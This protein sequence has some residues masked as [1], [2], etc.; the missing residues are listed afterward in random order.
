LEDIGEYA[1]DG[2][3]SLQRITTLHTVK[4]I[5]KSAFCNCKQLTTVQL[6]DGLEEI[7]SHA[8]HSCTLLEHIETPP[9]VKVIKWGT[10]VMCT[11]MRTVELGEGMEVIAHLELFRCTSLEHITITPTVTAINELA[12]R[13]CSH[14]TTMQFRSEIEQ[15]VSGESMRGW[16]N[17]WVHKWSPSTYCFLVRCN[18]FTTSKDVADPCKGIFLKSLLRV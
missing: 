18:G 9:D 10:F 8:F 16:W 1:F 3:T 6:G 13:G 5:K 14:L 4:A 12:I 2:C 17:H 11:R 15:F 7:G